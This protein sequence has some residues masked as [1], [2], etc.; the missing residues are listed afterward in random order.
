[1]TGI[2]LGKNANFGGLCE[3]MEEMESTK[4]AFALLF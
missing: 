1:M 4:E 3:I 2:Y